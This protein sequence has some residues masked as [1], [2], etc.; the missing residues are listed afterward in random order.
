[1]TLATADDFEEVHSFDFEWGSASLEKKY[2]VQNRGEAY[3][4]KDQPYRTKWE[5]FSP[6]E[7]KELYPNIHMSVR[8]DPKRTGKIYV[9]FEVLPGGNPQDIAFD[10]RRSPFISDKGG[11]VKVDNL[12]G[13]LQFSETQATQVIEKLHPIDIEAELFVQESVLKVFVGPYE[14]TLPLKLTF[15]ITFLSQFQTDI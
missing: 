1:M 5:E 10:F 4:L 14:E 3:P 12:M 2:F 8:P 7:L 9:E 13:S 11:S 6:F 15:E